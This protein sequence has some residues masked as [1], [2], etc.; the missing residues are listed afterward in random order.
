M[1]D[2][3]SGDEHDLQSRIEGAQAAATELAALG[4]RLDSQPA[5]ER[6][7][8]E[9]LD[10]A[11]A[12]CAEAES[13]A[14]ALRGA[15]AEHVW[16]VL[17]GDAATQGE[18]AEQAAAAARERVA[19]L[20]AA[21]TS[22]HSQGDADRTRAAD[23]RSQIATLGPLRDELA[24]ARWRAAGDARAGTFVQLLTDEEA[25][26]ERDRQLTEADS[27]LGAARAALTEMTNDLS[28]A[29]A[30]G[31]YDT[32]FGGGMVASAVKH[33]RI[34]SAN[35]AAGRLRDALGRLRQELADVRLD[36][37]DLQISSGR[38]TM[39][40]W[41][42]NIFTDASVQADIKAQEDRAAALDSGLRQVAAKL[43]E[44]RAALVTDRAAAA[45]RR[46]TLRPDHAG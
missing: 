15:H 9:S 16:H 45:A 35:D 17:R 37:A 10:A 2:G 8:S 19:T 3:A 12:T 26:D 14:E 40:I 25:L 23:L 22:I 21:L 29:H 43:A 42:D 24:L 46:A 39:D 36:A 5:S 30:W 7:A 6:A 33:N 27:A 38:R 13:R 44:L 1:V 41:F 34:D 28:S 31:T 32:W 18:Q 20:R 11:I 4:G